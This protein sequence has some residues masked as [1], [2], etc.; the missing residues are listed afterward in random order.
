[1]FFS[2]IFVIKPKKMSDIFEQLFDFDDIL[3]EPSIL[4]PIKSRSEINTRTIWGNLPLMTAPMDTVINQDNFHLFKNKG[5]IPILPRIPN[6]QSDWV[7]YNNFLSY[8][9]TDFQ[10]LFLREKVYVPI[11]ERIRVLIDIANG[12][13]TDLYE[14][15]KKAK[16][17]YGDEIYLMVGNVA[18]PK[19]FREY[20]DV[21]VDL[22]R[23]GIGNGNGCLTTVQTGVGYPMASLIEECYAIKKYNNYK[24]EIVADGGFKKFSDIIKA[25]AIGADYIMLGSILNKALES[26]GE[27]TRENGEIINQFS[28]ESKQMF[29]VEIPLYKTFRGM[30]TKEVQKSWG[31]GELTTSEGVVR[32]NKVEYTIEGW[33]KNFEDYLKSAM[34]YT[35]KKELHH[36]IGGVNYNMITQNSFRRFDK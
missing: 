19:T 3:I 35:G 7:D 20:C 6:P 32:R 27:T 10:R 24:T 17:M 9:L 8:S 16:I 36:F 34:S 29:H 31:K 4:S 15:V 21:G 23:I 28:E 30:S 5:I 11:S 26:A 1:M 2:Y 18:N 14:S 25:L 13:M 22:V 12:H 33:V